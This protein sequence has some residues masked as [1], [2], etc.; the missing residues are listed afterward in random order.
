MLYFKRIMI[1]LTSPLWLPVCFVLALFVV[2]PILGIAKVVITIVDYVR[3]GRFD[4]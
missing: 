2:L 4:D 3:T 1:V